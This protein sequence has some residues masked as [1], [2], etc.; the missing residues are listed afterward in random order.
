MM[1]TDFKAVKCLHIG[2][3]FYNWIC[4]HTSEI[5]SRSSIQYPRTDKC[6]FHNAIVHTAIH[7]FGIFVIVSLLLVLSQ[8]VLEVVQCISK[9]KPLLLAYTQYG[10]YQTEFLHGNAVINV[11]CFSILYVLRIALLKFE[12]QKA[13]SFNIT[14]CLNETERH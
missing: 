7:T 3:A 2:L 5:Y 4:R 13:F 8:T 6:E 11:A 10:T 14:D 12:Y 9:W 1:I